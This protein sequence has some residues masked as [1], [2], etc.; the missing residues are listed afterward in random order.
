MTTHRIRGARPDDVP[1]IFAMV[2]ELAEYEKARHEVQSSEELF[3]EALFCDKP[4]VWCSI[5]E[6]CP[7]DRGTADGGQWEI[8]GMAIWFRNFFTWTAKHSIYLDDLYVREQYRGLGYGKALLQHLAQICVERGYPRLD[9]WVLDWNPAV[10]FY[11]R[12]GAISMDD[13]T[14]NRLTGAPL[15]RLAAGRFD[16]TGDPEAV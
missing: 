4:A 14:V 1:E 11:K 7:D 12:I 13:W 2:C 3:T 15:E 10:E 5:L 6:H 9:W 16:D 8:A